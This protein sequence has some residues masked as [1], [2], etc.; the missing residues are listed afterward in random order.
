MRNGVLGW[1]IAEQERALADAGVLDPDRLYKD[2]LPASQVKKPSLVRPE[3][4]IERNKDLLRASGRRG[5][6]EIVVATML[7][8]APT[9]RDLMEVIDRAASRGATIRAIDSGV[10]IKPDSGLRGGR[11]ALDDW[12]RAREAARTKPGRTAGYIAAAEKKLAYTERKLPEARRLWRDPDNYT[13]EQVEELAGLSR[14]TLYDRL[15]R[16][17]KKKGTSNAKD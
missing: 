6:D 14:K 3:W 4:L 2:V 1:S 5:S 10:T 7:A 12:H 11:A 15:G 16:R 8:L 9:E 17:P 13:V